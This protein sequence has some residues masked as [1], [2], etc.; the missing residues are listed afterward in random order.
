MMVDKT[1]Y[2]LLMLKKS[3]NWCILEFDFKAQCSLLFHK[4][5][6]IKDVIEFEI[7]SKYKMKKMK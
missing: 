1:Q 2:F 3:L 5:V 6:I 4:N 7:F